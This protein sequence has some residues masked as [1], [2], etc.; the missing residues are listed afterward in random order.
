M[1]EVQMPLSVISKGVT[2][3][4]TVMLPDKRRLTVL[5]VSD[6]AAIMEPWPRW[7]YITNPCRVALIR[8]QCCLFPGRWRWWL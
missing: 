5:R 6:G 4:D 2:V 7:R 1:S 3:G 8:L